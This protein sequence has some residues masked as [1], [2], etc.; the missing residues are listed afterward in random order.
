MP[1]SPSKVT[2]GAQRGDGEELIARPTA[3]DGLVVAPTRQA[4]EPARGVNRALN[5]DARPGRLAL[6]GGLTVLH[7]ISALFHLKILAKLAHRRR[8][9]ET[10]AITKRAATNGHSA[11]VAR[12]PRRRRGAVA[13]RD[14]DHHSEDEHPKAHTQIV[15]PLPAGGRAAV[16]TPSSGRAGP[17]SGA[18]RG[19]NRGPR[20]GG[21][22]WPPRHACFSLFS[23]EAS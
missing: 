12:R 4:L 5:I 19:G 14:C 13:T 10:A 6:D 23:P 2:K 17:T 18:E 8:S 20:H 15:A 3:D 9:I 1:L 11:Q 7:T 22:D 16:S 21:A